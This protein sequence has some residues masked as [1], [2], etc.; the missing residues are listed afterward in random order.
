MKISIFTTPDCGY[1]TKLK[2]KLDEASIEYID[3][4]INNDKNNLSFGKI[5]E[6]TKE[7]SVPTVLVGTQI[8]APNKSFKT[9][10]EAFEIINKLM[11]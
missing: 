7:D 9:I 2:D 3:Y 4:D 6:I 5:V 8:L 11:N 1:C 10:N